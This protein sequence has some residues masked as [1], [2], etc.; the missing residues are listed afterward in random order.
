MKE[1]AIEDP[2]LRIRQD[3]ETGQ[4]ILE[5]MGELHIEV[6]K[7]RL[8]REYGLNVFMGPLQVGYREV[9][10]ESVIHTA[11]VEDQYGDQKFKQSCSLTLEIEPSIK[12]EKF[13][14]VTVILDEEQSSTSFVRPEWLKAINEG[15]KNA[16]YNG[17]VM[18]YPVHN[19]K[20]TLRF[21]FKTWKVY[22]INL[23]R[24]LIA[25]GGRIN[26]A[27]LS[28]CASECVSTAL[29]KSG[30]HLIEPVM[31]VEINIVD[32]AAEQGV[33][34][35]LQE[36]GK[37]R[38]TINGVTQQDLEGHN[39]LIE[40]KVPLSET[41]GISNSIRSIS[42]GLGAIH[43]QFLEYEHV[44]PHDQAIILERRNKGY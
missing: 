9:I 24:G 17:P 35:I 26:P 20:I 13:T 31:Q 23:F 21:V 44:P 39:I 19:V 6:I 22:A 43:M 18:G 33:S 40:A 27:I 41:S 1:L 37:R 10:N 38:A 29:K 16:L 2:S 11:S 34:G 8:N 4:T 5:G 3:N 12:D 42:S 7:E 25:S 30:A 15:C 36:L 14:K 32:E 28:A